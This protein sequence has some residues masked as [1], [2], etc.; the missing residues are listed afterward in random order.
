M[1]YVDWIILTSMTASAAWVARAAW[2][3]S[4]NRDAE[5][6]WMQSHTR[7]QAGRHRHG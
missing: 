4:R 6:G 1:T 7:T 3:Q 5:Q 2:R